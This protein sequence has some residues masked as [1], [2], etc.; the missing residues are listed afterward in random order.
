M[1]SNDKSKLRNIGISAH[2]D[3]G[4][5]TLTE[6]V[7]FYTGKVRKTGEVH[8]GGATMDFDSQEQERGITIQSA[9]TT[10][11]WNGSREQFGADGYTINIIDT[12]GHVDFTIEVERSLR[13]LDGVCI[14]L[15][16]VGGVEPQTETVWQQANRHN[17]PRM[18]FINKMDRA[19]ADF[20]EVVKQV[21]DRLGAVPVPMQLPIGKEDNFQGVVD[22]VEMKSVIWDDSTQGKVFDEGEIPADMVDLA[23]EH[24]EKML[25]A[26]AEVNDELMEM[27]LE[28]GDLPVEK[29][30]YALRQLCI[31][32]DIVPV[33]CGSAFK[34]KG[35]Q[36]FLDGVIELLPS[37]LDI[38]AIEAKT[39]KGEDTEVNPDDK[40]APAALAFKIVTDPFVG[41]LTYIRLYSG[42]IQTGMT[43]IN[44]NKGKKERIGR[45]VRMNASER[46]EIKEVR[47]GDI[48]AAIGL[49]DIH[50]GDT[51][52]G[53][54]RQVVLGRIESPE[55]VIHVSIEPKTKN[56]QE[57]LAI[58]LGKLS[59]EDP[60]FH[61]RTDEESGETI[62][63][64]MGELHLEVI[65]EKMRREHSVDAKVGK[66]QVAYRE[67]ITKSVEHEAKYIK[68]SGGRGQYGH[69]VIR[70]E[71]AEMGT[72][73]EFVNEIVGGVIPK[74]YIPS[75]DKGIQEQMKNGIKAGFPVE[76]IK[77]TLYDGSYHEVDSSEMAFKMAGMQGFK[78]SGLK[79]GPVLLE[80]IMNVEVI[81]PEEY[82]G[83]VVGDLNRRRGVILSM[84]DIPLGKSVITEV[85]LAEM[86]GFST[87][88]RS[89]TKGRAT[90]FMEPKKYM[91]V[92]AEIAE[93]I[94]KE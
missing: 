20:Y 25:E 89:M 44:T 23:N 49:K 82:T 50:T 43:L 33:F 45:L 66:P 18:I 26:A 64:G 22:L 67:S 12:P 51:L 58:A 59:R 53:A 47:A 48:A 71:P 16:S 7:L 90:F 76:D 60:S 80:P 30:K 63:A 87:D 86:F 54:D 69:I 83:T 32:N 8:D 2:V 40:E 88:L 3:A 29:L 42:V 62:I 56:D 9:A 61:V 72:G 35:V 19:G 74:E 4:K 10:C 73:Y 84:N 28:Q 75:V 11:Q 94:S 52:S 13:V 57:K 46:E 78:E 21:K 38:G 65:V 92:P 36:A 15:C 5:T 77:V 1:A 85:P 70:V 14:V 17:V 81:T 31:S 93:K 34:N 37:P 79:A 6:R 27:F 41:T 91:R 24:R 68:Q 39:L 55:P